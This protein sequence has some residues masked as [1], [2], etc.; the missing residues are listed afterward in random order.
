MIYSLRS[1]LF[2]IKADLSN[3]RFN[4]RNAFGRVCL[5]VAGWTGWGLSGILRLR[6]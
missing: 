6:E 2:A 4:L 5:R 1:Y 3:S